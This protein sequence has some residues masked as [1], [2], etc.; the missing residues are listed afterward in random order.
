MAKAV[1]VNDTRSGGPGDAE[2]LAELRQAVLDDW[3]AITTQTAW[4]VAEIKN[5]T[6]W[7]I[8]KPLRMIKRF[9]GAMRDDGFSVA[10]NLAISA[11]TRR[12]GRSS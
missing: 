4:A 11:V 12:L 6:S 5:S 3:I 10:T 1:R 8:T 7:R 9:Q 2:E